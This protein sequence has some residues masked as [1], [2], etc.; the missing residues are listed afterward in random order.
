[1][2]TVMADLVTMV[3]CRLLS[4]RRGLNGLEAPFIM[5]ACEE[6]G[7]ETHLDCLPLRI[8]FPSVQRKGFRRLSFKGTPAF[9]NRKRRLEDHP[10]LAGLF[11]TNA[12]QLPLSPLQVTHKPRALL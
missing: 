7:S 10:S 11:P 12:G 1:M 8:L 3:M 2:E 6:V 5:L 9:A 4:I